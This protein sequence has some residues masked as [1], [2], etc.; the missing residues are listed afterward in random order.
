MKHIFQWRYVLAIL[1]TLVTI[2][3]S[4]MPARSLDSVS[5]IDIPHFD[6]WGHFLAY[7]TLGFSWFLSFYYLKYRV[8][9]TWIFLF[10]LGILIELSQFYFLEGRYFEI[11]DIIAN[12]SG[13]IVGI[14]IGSYMMSKDR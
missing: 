14:A 11:L 6:K 13:A 7:C 8:F 5:I 1:L 12:I 3:M 2:T 4:V 9:K 10:C